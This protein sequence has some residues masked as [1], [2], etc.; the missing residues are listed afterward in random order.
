MSK[1]K[2]RSMEEILADANVI[3][4]ES[5]P[6]P[7]EIVTQVPLNDVVRKHVLESRKIIQD[8]LDRKDKRRLVFAGPCSI[9]DVKA[10][11]EYA[12]KLKKLADEVSDS[13]YLVMRTYLEKPRSII[14]WKGL[15]YDPDLNDSNDIGKG[16]FV[17][18]K[19]LRDV[20][21]LGVPCA[22]EFV[23]T[24]LPQYV[25]DL[26]SWA[27]IGARTVESQTHRELASGLSMPV[28]FKNNTSGDIR[29][30]A[31]A[32]LAASYSHVFLGLT[33][34]GKNCKV[35]TR[36]NHYGHIVLRGG[37]GLPNYHPE[38]VEEAVGYLKKAGLIPNV[39]VDCSHAN[40]NK[41]YEKQEEVAYAV[42]EQ[43]RG[44]NSN[45]VGI[46]M[47]SHLLDGK[48]DFPKDATGIFNLKYGLSVTDPCVSFETT[49]R[50]VR[51]YAKILRSI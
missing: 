45:I 49:E 32:C 1:I 50:I 29:V 38:K 41:V 9:H 33:M 37:N 43:I 36:G 15:L 48:Q 21:S 26:I 13:I 46:M 8:I 35:K 40:C 51:R 7:A 18:R 12:A 34:D 27:A 22:T 42:L 28:G 25:A 17:G 10:G 5:L 4:Y 31:D 47:E 14:G 39:V 6:S 3:N 44:G 19:F 2:P 11:L 23:R 16:V 20:V 30:A 24:D